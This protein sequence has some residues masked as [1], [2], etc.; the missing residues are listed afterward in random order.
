MMEKTKE[1]SGP[2]IEKMTIFI[3]GISTRG[4]YHMWGRGENHKVYK[5][6]GEKM[7][8]VGE[9]PIAV[10]A[11]IEETNIDYSSC[12]KEDLPPIIKNEIVKINNQNGRKVYD[13]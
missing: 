11:R 7:N 1:T 4:C 2:R 8:D 9:D 5:K 10:M 12:L 6:G 3:E 13:I